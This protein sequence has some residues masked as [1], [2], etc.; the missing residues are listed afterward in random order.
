LLC[1]TSDALAQVTNLTGTPVI[2]LNFEAD[3]N[4]ATVFC[5]IEDVAPDSSVTYVTEGLLRPLH[6]K[7][8]QAGA[9]K[10]IY[11]NHNY[12]RTDGE[13]YKSGET[14]KLDFDLL[15]I[16][17]QFKPGHRI[18]VS[19]AGAD[20]GHFI[21]P[22]PAASTFQISTNTKNPSYIELPLIAQ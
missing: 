20:A 1:F 8:T 15:P 10:T 9:Y 21:L 3:S 18:R 4:D 22:S 14:V 2:H 11:P 12:T 5:Y 13:Y 19:I 16:S 6:R 17:Y 7:I